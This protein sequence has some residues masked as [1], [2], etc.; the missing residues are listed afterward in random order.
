MFLSTFAIRRIAVL[1]NIFRLVHASFHE[2]LC[3][4]LS[5]VR[6]PKLEDF[7][8]LQI[9][10]KFIISFWLLVFSFGATAV[11]GVLALP[12]IL[13]TDLEISEK[14]NSALNQSA[15]SI[16]VSVMMLGP[17]V[18]EVIFRSW[19]AGTW[20][21]AVACVLSLLVIFGGTELLEPFL[22]QDNVS[23][24]LTLMIIVICVLVA[25]SPQDQDQ[26]IVGFA[27]VFPVLFY[28]QAIVFGVLHFQNYAASSTAVALFATLPLVACGF[29]WGYARIRVGLAFAVLL[30]VA[31]NVPAA[32]GSIIL[33]NM[34]G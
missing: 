12:V 4:L 28:I 3:G 22:P 10:E 27:R 18:E 17:L 33:V 32:I 23:H 25:F 8:G 9:S 20:R 19:L 7:E 11:I 1:S 26:P 30:H 31:Y 5:Y 15:L 13:L 6:R 29:I 16:I 2:A 24:K 14:L 21:S 34:A